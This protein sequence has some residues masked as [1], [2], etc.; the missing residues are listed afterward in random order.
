MK[1]FQELKSLIESMESD[2]QKFYIKRNAVAGTRLRQGMQ[3]VKSLA[4]EI[5]EDVQSLKKNGTPNR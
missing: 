2:F 1:K 3:A 4:Q 5:R